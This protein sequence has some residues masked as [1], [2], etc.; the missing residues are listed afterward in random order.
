MQLDH[1]TIVSR[2]L[3]EGA[4]FYDLLLP[5]LGFEKRKR[6]IWKNAS[7]LFLQFREA[8]AGTRDY[9]RYGPGLN[10]F[11]FAAPDRAAVDTVHAAITGAGYEARLQEFPDGTYALFIP[12]PDG[13]RVEFSH[14]PPGVPAV[15]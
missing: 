14:Y 9:E 4:A 7:G 5:L 12:D 13:L 1:L 8:E 2:D 10:H 3:E 6:G 15:D 11:G